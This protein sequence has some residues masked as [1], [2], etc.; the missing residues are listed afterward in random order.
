MQYDP[1]QSEAQRRAAAQQRAAAQRRAQAQ[2]RE[3]IRRARRNRRVLGGVCLVLLFLSVLFAASLFRTC[4]K[5]DTSVSPLTVPKANADSTIN[6]LENYPAYADEEVDISSECVLLIDISSDEVVCEKNS[7]EKVRIASLTKIMTAIVAI[8]NLED[9]QKTYIFSQDIINYLESE[10]S[11][12][13]GFAAGEEVSAI[14]ML[15]AAMLPS[16]GDGAMGI[17]DL[18]GGSQEGFVAMM[19]QKALALGMTRTHFTNA[20]GFDDGDNY[21]CAYDVSL[22]FEYALKNDTFRK[23]VTTESYTTSPTNEHPYGITLT[24]TV[25][26]GFEANDLAMDGILGGKTGF[27]TDAG[28]CLATYVEQNGE[29]YILITLGA[30]NGSN[31]PQYHFYDAQKLYAAFVK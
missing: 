24:S 30:G 23:I 11:A 18:V 17:A 2:R 7:T 26:H 1:R 12:V 9:M 29:E 28:L 4:G 3:R 20:T 13:A 10:N 22:M 27:T 16:G 6:E 14:D 8:E 15:Y 25:Y 31:Y 5:D 19:N 21:S